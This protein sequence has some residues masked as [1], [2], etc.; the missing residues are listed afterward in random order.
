MV[1]QS[2]PVDVLPTGTALESFV[3]TGLIGQGG[4]GI[5]YL[6]RDT[7]SRRTVAIKEFLPTPGPR[8]TLTIPHR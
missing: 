3:I 5:V 4:F 7:Q 2:T 1:A 6:A 8:R